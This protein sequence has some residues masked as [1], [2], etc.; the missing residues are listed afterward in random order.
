MEDIIIIGGGPAGLTAAIYA[1]RAGKQCLVIEAGAFGGQIIT[2]S[3]VVNYPGIKSFAGADFAMELYNQAKDFGAKFKTAKVVGIDLDADIKIVKTNK[4][5][6]QAKAVIIATGASSRPLGLE[7]ENKFLGKG[8]SYCATCDGA[9]YK[10]KD[11]AV[12]GGGNAA[13]EEALYLSDICKKVYLIHR[14]NEFR[15][16]ETVVEA[17]RQ[18]ENVEFVLEANVTDLQGDKTLEKIE[19]TKNSGEKIELE[20]SGLF[21][22]VGQVPSNNAFA[23][24][25]KLDKIGY[26]VAGEDCKTEIPGIFVAGDCRTKSL[27]QLVTAESDGAIAAIESISFLNQIAQK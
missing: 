16:A 15:A 11:V 12:V 9:F 10:G 5:D 22:A 26:V 23:N 8:V 27:R 7:N 4:G 18:K 3:N 2:T 21:V 13:I 24:V 14:R 17:L 1:Q 6:F 25:L 19:V 20:I